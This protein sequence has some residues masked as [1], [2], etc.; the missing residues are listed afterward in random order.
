MPLPPDTLVD[1]PQ[2]LPLADNGGATAT[3][4]LSETSPALDAGDNGA[5]LATDQRGAGFARTEGARTDIGAFEL[6]AEP[7]D[8]VFANGFDG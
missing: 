5:G 6:Q 1:D 3:H 7:P 8:R 2:L 4:A